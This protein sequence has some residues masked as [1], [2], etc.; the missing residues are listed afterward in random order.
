MPT[1]KILALSGSPVNGSST[2]RLVQAVVDSLVA[3]FPEG[4]T[5]R[6]R[7]VRL[8]DLTGIPCQS[9]G[10]APTTE[11]Q[12]CFFDDE[13]TGVYDDLA[14]CDCVVI[15]TP[16]YFDSVS[17]QTKLF[18]DRCNC[19]RPVDFD[20]TDPDHHFL[21]RITRSRPG[22]MV[23]V[24]GERGWFEGARRCIAGWFKWI[25]VEDVGA[26]IYRSRDDTVRGLAGRDGQALAEAA[27]LG[28]KLADAVIR[29]ISE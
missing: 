4:W 14:S 18:I 16:L 27:A 13:I 25:E 2:D 6:V 21:R 19:F 29:S 23:L 9:C 22:G 20:G 24:G 7:S 15:G 17:A 10:I 11:G 8:N 5:V 28:R 26:V 3:A 1:V 12:Y